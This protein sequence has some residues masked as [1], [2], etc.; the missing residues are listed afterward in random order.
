MPHNKPVVVLVGNPNSGKTTLFNALTGSQE[1]TGNYAGVTV[2]KVSAKMNL[3]SIQVDCLDVPGIYSLDPISLD[4]MVAI[5][6]INGISEE[7]IKPDLIVYVLDSNNLE[8]HLYLYSQLAESGIPIIVALTM[9]DIIPGGKNSIDLKIL[10]EKLS[11]D[12]IPVIYHTK[13]GIDHLRSSI[14]K[15]LKNKPIPAISLGEK[16]ENVSMVTHRYRWAAK[17]KQDVVVNKEPSK[18]KF[19]SDSIDKLLTNKFWGLLVFVALMLIVF[20]S[21]Y[22]FAGPIMEL[23]EAFFS[24]VRQYSREYLTDIP[25]LKSMIVNGIL[26]GVGTTVMFLPQISILFFFITVLESTGYLARAAFLMDKLLGWCGLNGRSFIPLMSS[27]AC[28]VPGIMSTRVIPDAKARLATLLVAPLM[29]CSARLPIY[30]LIIG[31]FIEPHLGPIWAGVTLF[32]MHILGLFVAIPVI[33]V[34]NKGIIKSP[35][36]P[37]IMELPNYQWPKW[38]DVF[39]LVYRRS[40]QFVKEAGSTIVVL[41]II[42]WALTSFPT[43]GEESNY[44][45]DNQKELYSQLEGSY[46]GKFGKF[47]EPVFTPLGFDWRISTAIVASFPA[48]EVVITSLSIMFQ[49]EATSEDSTDLR[50]I[51]KNAKNNKGEPIVDGWSA[52]G[53]MIFFALCCQCTATLV[54]IKNETGT[55]K[56]PIFVF[57]Y[58]T[59]LAYA[60]AYLVQIIKFVV[61]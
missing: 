41:S 37:F 40:K 15:S 55:W 48:R 17:V 18:R 59:L 21:I 46:L 33:F 7:N 20:E 35:Q 28:A 23:I 11:T 53:L 14:E 6:I 58:M 8:R 60:G 39:N 54:T 2:E 47:I 4:E 45:M 34:I 49:S 50:S 52:A 32:A 51:L 24:T 38:K 22:T 16:P 57:T 10:S 1:K 5:E 30:I 42:I 31:T 56:W 9:T 26:P 61:K 43:T 44:T 27:Y 13:E 19:T 25:I 12:V 29:S 36:M 3:A